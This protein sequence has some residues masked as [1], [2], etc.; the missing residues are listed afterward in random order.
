[1]NDNLERIWK[2][3]DAAFLLG[4]LFNVLKMEAI[5]TSETSADFYRNTGC[6]LPEENIIRSVDY[7]QNKLHN[8]QVI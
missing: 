1:M 6:H 4:S 8:I 3:A 7:F 5:P 2:E